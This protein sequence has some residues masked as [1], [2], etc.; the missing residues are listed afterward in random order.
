MALTLRLSAGVGVGVAAGLGVGVG[1]G[2]T[3]GMTVGAPSGDV[4]AGRGTT[5]ALTLGGTAAVARSI[6]GPAKRK[7]S[8]MMP[9]TGTARAPTTPSAT[10]NWPRSHPAQRCTRLRHLFAECADQP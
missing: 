4:M 1:V 2:V 6:G 9:T 3:N 10:P 8:T 5:G 7:R